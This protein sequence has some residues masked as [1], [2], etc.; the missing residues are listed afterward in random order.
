VLAEQASEAKSRF[1]ATLGHEVRTPMTGVL[2]MSE[3]LRATRLDDRQRSQVDAI[4][5]AGEHLLRLV[6]DALDLARIEA[7]KLEL[8]TADF[9]LRPLLDELAGLMA[10]VAS[11]RAWRSSMRLRAC[12]RRCMATAPGSSTDPAQPAGQC[13]QVHRG[14]ARVAGSRRAGATRHP[15]RGRRY[16]PRAQPSSNRGCSAASN[17]PKARALRR[18]M[19]AAGWALRSARNWRRRWAAA[20]W[21]KASL[22]AGHALHRR[23][24]AGAFGQRGADTLQRRR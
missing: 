2:G 17:R 12:P 13:D 24:A 14:R 4:H 6:N 16:R 8:A 19:A 20:S 18:A 11:A 7:G 22:G 5:R 1:L 10:P 15:F 21:W 23:T 3:L 9:A